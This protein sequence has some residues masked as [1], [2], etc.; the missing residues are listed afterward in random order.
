MKDNRKTRPVVKDIAIGSG[1]LG[2]NSL[3]IRIDHSVGNGSPPLRRF[4]VAVL[5]RRLSREDEYYTLRGN[6]AE[7]GRL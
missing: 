1:G 6:T 7:A 4:F 5:F 3:A 2:F